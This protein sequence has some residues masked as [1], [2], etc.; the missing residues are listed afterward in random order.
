[1]ASIITVV[2]M[3][4][5]WLARDPL[6][7]MYTDHANIV[8]LIEYAWPILIIFTFFDTT[9]A[10]GSNFIKSSGNQ[11]LGAIITGS[12]YF[13]VGIPVSYYLAFSRGLELR[14]LWWGPT[15]AVAYNTFWYNII[16]YRIDWPE[17]IRSV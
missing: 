11:G 3:T 15:L 6:I 1:V 5:L 14:G 8:T 7:R 12:A 10:L 13:I 16:I 2:Q 17:L 4:L 9:Q